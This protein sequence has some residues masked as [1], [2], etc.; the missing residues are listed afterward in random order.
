M[1]IAEI[2]LVLWAALFTTLYVRIAYKY[3]VLTKEFLIMLIETK[4]AIK[5]WHQRI[6]DV[7]DNKG[8][9]VRDGDNIAYVEHP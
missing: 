2:F 7:A 6:Q 9:F 8:K 4:D 3:S 1:S 5:Q